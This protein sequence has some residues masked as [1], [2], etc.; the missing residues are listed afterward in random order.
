MP[1]LIKEVV[2]AQSGG[3]LGRQKFV[4]TKTTKH[5]YPL[6]NKTLIVRHIS[7]CAFKKP[8]T[9]GSWGSMPAEYATQKCRVNSFHLKTWYRRQTQ[10]CTVKVWV[11]DTTLPEIITSGCVAV[12]QYFLSL[13]ASCVNRSIHSLQEKALFTSISRSADLKET[14]TIS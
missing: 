14:P 4:L 1:S 8:Q 12:A 3:Y 10:K 6:S 11:F 2:A 9:H 13:V 5:N 7:H